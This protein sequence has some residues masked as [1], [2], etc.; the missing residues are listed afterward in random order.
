MP[1][2]NQ[3]VNFLLAQIKKINEGTFFIQGEF[4]II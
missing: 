4:A 1:S 3:L 2:A